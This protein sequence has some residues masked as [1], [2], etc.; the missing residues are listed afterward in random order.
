[1]SI[2]S[3]IVS[4]QQY[5]HIKQQEAHVLHNT[6]EVGSSCLIHALTKCK[7]DPKM[8]VLFSNASWCSTRSHT[9]MDWGQKGWGRCPDGC[10][11]KNLET[12][13][14]DNLARK[15]SSGLWSSDVYLMSHA[16]GHCY[17]YNPPEDGISSF[18]GGISIFLGPK[19]ADNKDL[20]GHQIYIHE[21]DQFWPNEN[22]PSVKRFKQGLNKSSW[23]YFNGWRTT[24][25][26]YRS[27]S[28]LT[29]YKDLALKHNF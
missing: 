18:D 26:S 11:G 7:T 8:H 19:N 10:D 3:P 6:R 17:T 25:L 2:Q 20:Y 28:F 21:K 14:S 22:L 29:I 23:I 12:E 13:S 24:K 1:M 5:F 27:N 16:F 15:A 4:F 9:E